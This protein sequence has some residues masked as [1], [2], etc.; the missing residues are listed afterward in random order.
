MEY[1]TLHPDTV[2]LQLYMQRAGYVL[3]HILYTAAC[4]SHVQLDIRV[5]SFSAC[6]FE[7]LGEAQGQ[8]Y[9]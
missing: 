3:K 7:I 4:Y 5:S 1:V 9:I 8:G 2:L 6:N